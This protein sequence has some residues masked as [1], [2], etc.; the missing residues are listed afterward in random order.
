MSR[1]TLVSREIEDM[2]GFI[3]GP[4]NK[5]SSIWVTYELLCLRRARACIL[6]LESSDIRQ[7]MVGVRG[8]QRQD[9]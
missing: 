1:M 4:R 9:Q 8:E 2:E 3:P 7:G 5:V 6:T